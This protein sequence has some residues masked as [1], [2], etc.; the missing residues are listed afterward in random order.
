M[1]VD[2]NKELDYFEV[3]RK[4]LVLK[5]FIEH[6]ST[7]DYN[8]LPLSIKQAIEFVYDYADGERNENE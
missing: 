2:Y 8:R 3:I 5:S 6:T 7:D 4:M 1:R